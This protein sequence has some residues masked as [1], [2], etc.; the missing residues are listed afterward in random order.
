MQ[1][2]NDI[3][4][5]FIYEMK[6]ETMQYIVFEQT[7]NGNRMWRTENLSEFVIFCVPLTISSLKVWE[8]PDKLCDY[9][10][11][12]YLDYYNEMETDCSCCSQRWCEPFSVSRKRLMKR[13]LSL[14]NQ[15]P[16][17]LVVHYMDK[18]GDFLYKKMYKND[19]DE[20]EMKK[21]ELE[22]ELLRLS[23]R[24]Y[25][26]DYGVIYPYLLEKIKKRWENM[27]MNECHDVLSILSIKDQK[28]EIYDTLY[29]IAQNLIEKKRIE[30]FEIM[31]ENTEYP[32]DLIH[33]ILTF[34]C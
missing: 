31:K 15:F 21:F 19:E 1:N 28:D 18:N 20:E 13:L 14:S 27:E 6:E 32:V 24:Q 4:D 8:F 11:Y 3:T 26:R 30:T 7:N 25:Q 12:I 10:N 2:I 29:S 16:F 33:T 23:K 22:I 5:D 17:S 9:M 34:V